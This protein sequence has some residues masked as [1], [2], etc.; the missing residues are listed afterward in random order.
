MVPTLIVPTIWHY[1]LLQRMLSSIDYPV[2]HV[3][4][5]DNGGALEHAECE[6]A[7]KVSIVN[8]PS[9]LGVGPSWNL[10]I[11]LSPFSSWWLICN[12]D[13]VWNPGA[14]RLY[15]EAIGDNNIVIGTLSSDNTFSGFAI[16]ESVIRT[17]GLFDEFYYPGVG[18]EINYIHR[19]N[20]NGVKVKMIPDAYSGNKSASR[21]TMNSSYPKSL[22]AFTQNMQDA[23]IYGRETKG[24]QLD[25]RRETDPTV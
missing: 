2:G 16:H 13:I 12:D 23:I 10:G 18:E 15:D 9:N 1:D 14:L 11:K 25:R 17:V 7:D 8:L 20:A 3:I 6:M 21:K 19:M 24:W 4:I 5:I 22:Y